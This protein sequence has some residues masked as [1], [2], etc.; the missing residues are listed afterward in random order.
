MNQTIE[1]L[2]D[3]FNFVEQYCRDFWVT[4]KSSSFKTSPTKI[5]EPNTLS[6]TEWDIWNWKA[7]K[8]SMG[9]SSVS[10][11]SATDVAPRWV[12]NYI[13]ATQWGR[14]SQGAA[15]LDRKGKPMESSNAYP[16]SW[17][18]RCCQNR[19]VTILCSLPL[20]RSTGTS[21]L[22]KYLPSIFFFSFSNFPGVLPK[23]RLTLGSLY[24]LQS[25]LRS[26]IC[27][28]RTLTA[29]LGR[30]PVWLQYSISLC[31]CLL[32]AAER[33]ACEWSNLVRDTFWCCNCELV[34]S[35]LR[36]GVFFFPKENRV[37]SFLVVVYAFVYFRKRRSW[38]LSCSR[39]NQRGGNC[40]DLLAFRILGL[41]LRFVR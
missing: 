22:P 38:L 20:H 34:D 8:V 35:F 19:I 17:K 5:L 39:P 28:H 18:H 9:R 15:Q 3:F 30:T 13:H 2:K 7:C 37:R 16:A 41:G 32:P 26:R 4:W 40:S 11:N 27:D 1:G 6:K 10:H 21:Q 33:G 29:L 12:R 23:P 24:H 31:V 36:F 25:H 14:W